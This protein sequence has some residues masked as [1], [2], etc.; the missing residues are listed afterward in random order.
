MKHRLGV[1]VVVSL[2]LALAAE[3]GSQEAQWIRLGVPE[4]GHIDA[5]A[6]S[7]KRIFAAARDKV[8]LSEDRG[9]TW[10]EIVGETGLIDLVGL[11]SRCSL[12]VTGGDL[13]CIEFFS[14]QKYKS[15]LAHYRNDG[16]G[17][18]RVPPNY[19]NGLEYRFSPQTEGFRSLA[20]IGKSLHLFGSERIYRSNDGGLSWSKIGRAPFKAGDLL[21]VA[22]AGG[23]LFASDGAALRVSKNGG[24]SWSAVRPGWPKTER[25]RDLAG[26]DSELLALSG[27]GIFRTR[28]GGASWDSVRPGWAARAVPLALATGA[29]LL[30]AGTTLGVFLSTDDGASW[31]QANSGLRADVIHRLGWSRRG[32]L[33]QTDQGLFLSSD[34]GESWTAVGAPLFPGWNVKYIG[35]SGAGHY[36]VGPS[37]RVE[38]RSCLYVSND[39]ARTW[40]AVGPDLPEEVSLNFDYIDGVVATETTL[41]VDAGVNFLITEPGGLHW[42]E[43]KAGFPEKATVFGLVSKGADLFAHT[44]DGLY[45]STDRGVTWKTVS[46]GWPDKTWAGSLAVRGTDLYVGTDRGVLVSRD[47][48]ASWK[49]ANRGLPRNRPEVSALV[50]DGI[51][52]YAGTGDGIY[53]SADGGESWS[54]VG[55]DRNVLLGY[56]VIGGS[57]LYTWLHRFFDGGSHAARLPLR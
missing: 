38:G 31:R 16:S 41:V 37:P 9:G 23:R 6:V 57:N 52:L 40:K 44:G 27:R 46:S 20:A 43:L 10:R 47:D 22:A 19:P 54:R 35:P 28:D 26:T 33:A 36:A 51:K 24:A 21:C 2:V 39:D 56:L 4:G 42:S 11:E 53:M 15:L 55:G 50:T 13:Y 34:D 29:G 5:I 12:V 17:W 25:I 3:A 1:F 7:E 18:T 45:R 8:F 30:C 49:I 14:G 48:G 32:L